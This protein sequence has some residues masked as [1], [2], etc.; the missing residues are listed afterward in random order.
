VRSY[1]SL[2]LVERAFRCMKTVDLQVRP[3]HELCWNLGD[4]VIRRRAALACW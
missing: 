1:K 2:A 3:V 4:A